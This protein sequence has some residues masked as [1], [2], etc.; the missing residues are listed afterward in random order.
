MGFWYCGI[1]FV[2]FEELISCFFFFLDG[3]VEVIG[4]CFVFSFLVSDIVDCGF[5]VFVISFFGA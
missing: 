4:Y 5:M 3:E 2:D 1:V